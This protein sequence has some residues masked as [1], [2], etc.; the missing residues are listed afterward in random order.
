VRVDV[1]AVHSRVAARTPAGALSN[2][3]AVINRPD[4]E[5]TWPYGGTLDLRMTSEAKVEIG[6][7]QELGVKG[8]VRLMAGDTPVAQSLM[9]EKHRTG[10][11]PMAGA[12]G[13][14]ETGHRQAARRLE[15]VPPVRIVALD[16][17]H[18]TLQ[19][20]M[21]MREVEL[22]AG[23]EVTGQTG[24]RIPTRVHNELV[25][26]AARR[27]VLAARTVAGLAAGVPD[28]ARRLD[29]HPRMHAGREPTNQV[30]VAVVT[31]RVTHEVGV[32]DRGCDDQCAAGT[33][34]RYQHDRRCHQ[35]HH[36]HQGTA[37]AHAGPGGRRGGSG[38]RD[39][40]DLP[41]RARSLWGARHRFRVGPVRGLRPPDGLRC[42]C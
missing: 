27:H 3:V 6:L 32:G 29:M 24:R 35:A 37:S 12:T 21:P 33:C 20:R 19:H 17:V 34:A 31:R 16:A 42:G 10:L 18:A 38:G 39:R 30:R 28:P 15:D 7:S 11:F 4:H 9:L 40:A 26:A 2:E 8:T 13:V 25:P 41:F 23:G 14:V 5:L 1:G 22:R 36:A